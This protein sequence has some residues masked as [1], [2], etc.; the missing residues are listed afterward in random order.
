MSES[1][2]AILL[3]VVGFLIG[4]YAVFVMQQLWNWFAVPLLH[5]GEA[6]FLTIYG[7][8]LLVGL[9]T[10]RN[11][12][13]DPLEASRWRSVMMAIDACVPV[14]ARKALHE[15]LKEE[16][17]IQWLNLGTWAFGHASSYTVTLILG[18]VIHLL[19]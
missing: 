9:L 4:F 13:E 14:E 16:G 12:G 10:A 8:S 17:D 1:K 15:K 5:F 3:W 11:V 7:L 18:F 2:K 6:S 19:H